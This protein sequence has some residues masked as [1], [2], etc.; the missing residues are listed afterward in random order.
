MNRLSQFGRWVFNY[1]IVHGY[2]VYFTSVTK[3]YNRFSIKLPVYMKCLLSCI[4]V[5]LWYLILFNQKLDLSYFLRSLIYHI[6]QKLDCTLYF[7]ALGRRDI[8]DAARCTEIQ[9][10]VMP[11]GEHAVCSLQNCAGRPCARRQIWSG[12]VAA[13][14]GRSQKRGHQNGR[15]TVSTSQVYHARKWLLQPPGCLGNRPICKYFIIFMDI[16]NSNWSKC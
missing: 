4:V 15:T 12:G 14:L 11:H 10:R 7:A 16:F 9:D 13:T 6:N 5:Q 8:T 2:L 1:F 3:M